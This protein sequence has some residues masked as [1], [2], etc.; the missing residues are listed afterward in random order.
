[1]LW[2]KGATPA[3]NSYANQG[4]N[5]SGMTVTWTPIVPLTPPSFTAMQVEGSDLIMSGTG[6]ANGSYAVLIAADANAAV[7]QWT[8]IATN[9]FD[10]AGNFRFTN[11]ISSDVPARFY[12]LKVQ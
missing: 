2:T 11:T 8:S 9:T 3:T 6:P 4:A 10:G 1:L 5:F 12:R 7:A